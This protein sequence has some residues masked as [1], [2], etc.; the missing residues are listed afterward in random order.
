MTT[1]T[2]V[3]GREIADLVCAHPKGIRLSQ[4]IEAVAMRFGPAAIFHTSSRT[5]LDLDHMLVLLETR[6]KLQIVK[7]VVFPCGPMVRNH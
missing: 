7:G 1:P 2:A 3:H 4:L 6:N 5:G